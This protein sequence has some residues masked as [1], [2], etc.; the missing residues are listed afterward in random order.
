[1]KNYLYSFIAFTFLLLLTYSLQAQVQIGLRAGLNL[2][3]LQGLNLDDKADIQSFPRMTVTIP[4]E[5]PLSD[6]WSLQSEL[7]FTQRGIKVGFQ[8]GENS[9]NVTYRLNYMDINLL[10]K[11]AINEPSVIWGLLAGPSFNYGINA[12][13][14]SE[15]NFNGNTEKE[16]DKVTFGED[17][18]RKID[19]GMQAGAFLQIPMAGGS[20][21]I[22]A[23]YHLGLMNISTESDTDAVSHRGIQ[24]SAGF[25]IPIQ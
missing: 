19:L 25:M 2:A 22:D 20:A 3:T 23:R 21:F 10:G 6:L 1:M 15:S 8:E 17:G 4:V 18:L 9:A 5:I 11:I 7:G 12:K 24:L 14:I 16:E 13:L